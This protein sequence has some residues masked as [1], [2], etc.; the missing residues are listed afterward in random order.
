MLEKLDDLVKNESEVKRS[1]GVISQMIAH[2]YLIE[3]SPIT[4]DN[5]KKI[6]IKSSKLK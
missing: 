5:I 6:N 2:R 1:M 4:K 3:Q